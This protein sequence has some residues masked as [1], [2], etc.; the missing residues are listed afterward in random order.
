MSIQFDTV[1]DT[2]YPMSYICTGKQ[3]VRSSLI[4]LVF[5]FYLSSRQLYQ[6][7]VFCNH[8]Q[9]YVNVCLT[10]TVSHLKVLTFRSKINGT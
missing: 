7:Q 6:K 10:W 4:R 1:P 2:L 3:N 5:L 8:M 9:T